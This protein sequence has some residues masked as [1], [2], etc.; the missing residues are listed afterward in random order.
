[1]I[2][3]DDIVVYDA[4]LRLKKEVSEPTMRTLKSKKR[5][6]LLNDIE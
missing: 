5:M 3:V 2:E 4:N 1:M 6:S